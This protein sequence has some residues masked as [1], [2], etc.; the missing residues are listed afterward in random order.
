ML[1]KHKPKMEKAN[2]KSV[3]KSF[4]INV[5]GMYTLKAQRLKTPN[6]M[7]K[8]QSWKDLLTKPEILEIL[9]E[10]RTS[11]RLYP[12]DGAESSF[13]SFFWTIACWW[14]FILAL[15]RCTTTPQL[16]VWVVGMVRAA[17]CNT[18]QSKLLII[19]WGTAAEC[20]SRKLNPL[21]ALICSGYFWGT[22]AKKSLSSDDYWS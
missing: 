11:C 10:Q 1:I 6:P 18:N 17:R 13:Q 14:V 9:V 3:S 4:M 22:F 8:V 20:G 5:W 21:Y 7:V 16:L 12:R 2:I 19:F 15:C